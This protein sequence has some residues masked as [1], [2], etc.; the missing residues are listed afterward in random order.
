[1][2]ATHAIRQR[3]EESDMHVPII[4]LTANAM[5]GDR[6]RCLTEGMDDYLSKPF[7]KKQLAELLERWA[8]Y[9]L[10]ELD[11]EEPRQKEAPPMKAVHQ[12][13]D[14]IILSG[15]LDSK[16]LDEIRALNDSPSD[17]A[18]SEI[19]SSYLTDAPQL[20]SEIEL[21]LSENDYKRVQ[22][23][24]HTLKSSSASLGAHALSV[25]C[26]DLEY[27]GRHNE[28]DNIAYLCS[29]IKAEYEQVKHALEY[30]MN[31]DYN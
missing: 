19:I 12:D 6:E 15:C 24:A 9:T 5:A 7:R 27:K 10:V 30:E 20:L 29:Q 2:E 25:L 13:E 26:K 22:I 21:A 18:F 23:K 4:A 28:T 31:R 14:A 16:A 11:E 8:P 3:E 17:N 1:M